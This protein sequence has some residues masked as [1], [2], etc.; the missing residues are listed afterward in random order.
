[1]IKRKMPVKV[2]KK[3]PLRKNAEEMPNIN[4]AQLMQYIYLRYT[5]HEMIK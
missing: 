1:M 2:K 5:D 4:N 3:V